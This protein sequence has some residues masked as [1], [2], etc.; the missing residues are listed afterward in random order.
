MAIKYGKTE[1]RKVAK[2]LDR[3]YESA[4]EAAEAVLAE[5]L[6]ILEARGKFAV[7]GQL[8][9]SPRGGWVSHEDAAASKVC[10]GLYSTNGD[11]SSAAY[12]LTYGHNTG[13]QFKTWILP[14]EHSTPTDL[15]KK[16]RDAHD[17]AVAAAKRT[18]VQ[19]PD[20]EKAK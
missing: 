16:R 7:V 1:V 15:F 14:V 17:A 11:A 18:A 6:A 2:I 20:T 12:G 9:Y 8:Y 19:V 4:E 3:E 5:A 10:L 13:E